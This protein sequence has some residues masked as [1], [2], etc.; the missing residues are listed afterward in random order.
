M[1]VT[2]V[3]EVPPSA[4]RSLEVSLLIEIENEKKKNLL[5]DTQLDLD[6][7]EKS[8]NPTPMPPPEESPAGQLFR[9]FK[10]RQTLLLEF[11]PWLL[12]SSSL[13]GCETIYSVESNKK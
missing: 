13:S 4:T 3:N 8:A 2:K 11:P 12:Y 6:Y 9:T 10:D 5:L 1:S 7:C